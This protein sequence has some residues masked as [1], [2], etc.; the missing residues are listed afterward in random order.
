MAL[1]EV[2]WGMILTKLQ[3]V[4]PIKEW[5]VKFLA[6]K[7]QKFS[8]AWVKLF[9]ELLWLVVSNAEKF[10]AKIKTDGENKGEAAYRFLDSV[11]DFPWY[12]K[13]FGIKGKILRFV[14]DTYVQALNLLFGQNWITQTKG[15]KK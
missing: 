6:L 5:Q 10:A 15:I 2:E 8:L 13:L 9:T 11:V 12:L 7:G 14:V 3:D 4:I 1:I